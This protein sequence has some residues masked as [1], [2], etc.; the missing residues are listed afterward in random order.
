ME[1]TNA[2]DTI[3]RW[4]SEPPTIVRFITRLQVTFNAACVVHEIKAEINPK[5]SNCGEFHD[6]SAIPLAMTKSEPRVKLPGNASL[7]SRIKVSKAVIR[8]IPHLDV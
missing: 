8:G 1:I 4:A 5:V 2:T 6:A 3:D 7:P